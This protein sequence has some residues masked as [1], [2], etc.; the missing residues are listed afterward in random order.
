M[1]H[2]RRQLE[3]NKLDSKVKEDKVISMIEQSQGS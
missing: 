2:K 3:N 1:P